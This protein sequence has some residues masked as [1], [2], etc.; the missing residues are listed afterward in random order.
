VGDSFARAS[1]SERVLLI[2]MRSMMNRRARD[3]DGASRKS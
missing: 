2:W 3:R 1:G